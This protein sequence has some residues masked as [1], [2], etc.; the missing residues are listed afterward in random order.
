ME[1]FY[2]KLDALK[3][4][5]T[6]EGVTVALLDSGIDTDK[7]DID[8]KGGYNFADDNEDYTDTVGHGTATA[9][10]IKGEDEEGVAP[11]AD[12]LAVK[13]FNDQGRTDSG[14][15][16]SAIRYAVDMGAKVLAMPFSLFPVYDDVKNAINYA[17][18]NGAILIASAGNAGSEI[19]D[20]TL[21][22]QENVITVGSID[23]DGKLSVW[24]NYGDS[25]DI[26]APWDVTTLE[27][28]DESEAGTSYS[29]AFIS[30]VV[31]LMLS[32]NPEMT[33]EDIFN[34]LWM[35]SM[36]S[37]KMETSVSGGKEEKKIRG[38]SVDEVVSM[39]EVQRKNRSEFTGH[40]IKGEIQSNE[41]MLK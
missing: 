37:D 39:Q 15:V 41:G 36:R 30:G 18:E 32:E 19:E 4:Q 10:V 35:F 17:A 28:A 27:K 23:E 11:G 3:A 25:L 38:V 1:M 24:S 6:G 14:I 33:F 5:T 2:E 9:S 26:V 22:S 29:A 12:I 40:A 7:L 13:I 21:A 16:S 8:V 20:N 31:A 34:E